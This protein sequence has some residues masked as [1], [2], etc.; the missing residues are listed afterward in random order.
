MKVFRY[1]KPNEWQ[2]LLQRP[3]HDMQLVEDKVYPVLM[4]VKEN[5][6]AA[7]KKYSELFDKVVPENFKVSSEEIEEAE[8]KL[9]EDL[10]QSIIQAKD[11]I[12]TFHLSQKISEPIVEVM[13]GVT[14]WRKSLPIERVGLYIPGGTAPLFST[15]LMLAVP[16]QIA[17]CKE[18]V[19]CT[20]PDKEGLVHPAILFAAKV[21]GVSSIYKVGGAQAIAALAFG[22]ESIPKT[23][24]IFGPGNTYVTAAK[25]LIS[26][27]G[28]AI[29]MP[30]GPSEVLV[31]G[32][33][34]SNP[35]FLASDLL[36][37]AEH[38]TDSQVILLSTSEKVINQTL[39]EIK[40][41]LNKLSRMEIA[42]KS[43]ENS[44][45]ILLNTMEECMVFSNQYAPEHLIISTDNAEDYLNQV[46]NAGSVFIGHYS[47]ESAG[48]YASGTNH[49]LPTNGA[50]LAYSGASLDSF[51]KKVTFQKLSYEGL[52]KIGKTVETMAAAEG[53]DAHKNAITIRLKN[54]GS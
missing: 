9:S 54:N 13:D 47:P 21:A 37:Q 3:T 16:A 14:C 10:K 11:N 6:D 51:M 32:D 18:I 20:P 19:L 12:H 41:Q 30:A 36:S 44:R 46:S 43:L 49:T 48:D 52:Q 31:I 29:D 17:G 22:T 42:Q 4:E 2:I 27:W 25:Q 1:P 39:E 50:A 40:I 26:R 28:T 23:Y 5:G 35:A 33:E 34:S 45:C 8:S 53:L 38:G 24:K 7:L 15:V